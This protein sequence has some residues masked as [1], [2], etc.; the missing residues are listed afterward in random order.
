MPQQGSETRAEPTWS[1]RPFDKR[2]AKELQILIG[3]RVFEQLPVANRQGERE[4]P[5]AHEALRSRGAAMDA[6]DASIN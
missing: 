4:R 6:N 5:L 2:D 1:I 3:M